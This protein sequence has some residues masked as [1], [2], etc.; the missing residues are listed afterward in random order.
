MSG[1]VGGDGCKVNLVAVL[2][3]VTMDV[4]VEGDSYRIGYSQVKAAVWMHGEMQ[5]TI[6]VCH[7]SAFF[8]A[9]VVSKTG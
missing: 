4:V 7:L 9:A 8:N 2:A 1:G 5:D 6:F 3:M